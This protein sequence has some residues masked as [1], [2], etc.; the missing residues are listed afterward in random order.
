MNMPDI[1]II[2]VR[3]QHP[4]NI[5]ACARAM[6]NM[7]LKNLVL[8]APQCFLAEEAVA[9][10][11]GADDILAG[12]TVVADVRA[13]VA[14]CVFVAATSARA[15]TIAWPR[16][17]PRGAAAT[18]CAQ[19]R[20]GP[21]GLLFGA[22][23]TGLT[24]EEVDYAHALV[25]IP[26]DPGFASLNLAAAVQILCYEVRCAVQEPVPVPESDHRPAPQEAFNRFLEH[27]EQ[28]I[29]DIG[30]LNTHHPR[31]LM[32]RLTRLFRRAQ[33]DDNELQILRGILNAVQ[34]PYPAQKGPPDSDNT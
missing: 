30:F 14:D 24:N 1:R 21:V 29:T 4:G 28:V 26:V 18:L 10:A 7:G 20:S 23:R 16:L 3:P 11:A 19:A 22:E 8:V 27:L 34:N 6:K 9:R 33:P 32:R 2:L 17:E 15:R 12:A 13:A 5:G 31:K 25:Q